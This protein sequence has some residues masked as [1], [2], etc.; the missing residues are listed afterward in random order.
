MRP[1][2]NS[3]I[4]SAWMFLRPYTRA[5]PSPMVRTRPVSSS[6]AFSENPMILC[7][8]MD[9]TSAAEGPPADKMADEVWGGAVRLTAGISVRVRGQRRR[10]GSGQLGG[11]EGESERLQLLRERGAQRSARS[12]LTRGAVRGRT[13]VR[14]LTARSESILDLRESTAENACTESRALA[15]PPKWRVLSYAH[16]QNAPTSTCANVV[17][18]RA[19]CGRLR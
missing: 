4:S 6:W 12:Q 11:G 2:E 8:R 7:S 16:A 9:D 17:G 14:P 3:T 13:R 19:L 18:A 10:D 15:S 5:I 1:L